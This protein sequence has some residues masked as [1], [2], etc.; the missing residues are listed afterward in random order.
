MIA[1]SCGITISPCIARTVKTGMDIAGVDNDG[2]Y[3]RGGLCRSGQR[4]R[5]SQEV[6]NDGVD[7]IELS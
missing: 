5:K 4:L 6:D 3:C 1:L 2:G 7:Y